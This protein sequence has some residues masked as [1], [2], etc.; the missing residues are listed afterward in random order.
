LTTGRRLKMLFLAI[1]TWEPDKRNEVIKRRAEKGAMI[2]PG[3]KLLGEWTAISGG[4]VFRL[5]DSEDPKAALQ[6]VL[7]WSDLG[8]LEMIP[9][10]ETEAAMKIA[11][12]R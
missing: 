3:M 9:V 1:Y 2:P 4:K 5:I 10:I 8:K 6:A 12:S 11:I 7:G